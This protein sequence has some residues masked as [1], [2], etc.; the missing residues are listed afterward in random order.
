[1]VDDISGKWTVRSSPKATP[2]AKSP[3]LLP[4]ADFNRDGKEDLAVV[5]GFGGP[6]SPGLWLNRSACALAR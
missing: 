1:M 3:P 4:L 5:N 2:R 6:R